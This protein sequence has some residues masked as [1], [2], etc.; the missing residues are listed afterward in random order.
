VTPARLIEIETA[1]HNRGREDVAEL[2]AEVRRLRGDIRP[3]AVED[4]VERRGGEPVARGTRVLVQ[5]LLARLCVAPPAAV[6][7]EYPTVDPRLIALL[8]ET[9]P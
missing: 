6:C 5:A 7:T 3:L 4:L 1:P 8:D 2:V 9:E